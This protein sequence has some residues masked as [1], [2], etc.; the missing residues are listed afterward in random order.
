MWLF[1]LLQFNVFKKSE[2]NMYVHI[3]VIRKLTIVELIKAKITI[4]FSS[5][6]LNVLDFPTSLYSLNNSNLLNQYR[7]KL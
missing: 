7:L 6:K 5:I 4:I 1:Q 2:H 3:F